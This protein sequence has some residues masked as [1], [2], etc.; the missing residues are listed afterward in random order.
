MRR[1][2]HPHVFV[3]KTQGQRDCRLL[4][5][6]FHVQ[7]IRKSPKNLAFK[8]LRSFL[9]GNPFIFEILVD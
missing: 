8:L 3:T 6:P 4:P 9:P 7:R 1:S 2:L 5:Q